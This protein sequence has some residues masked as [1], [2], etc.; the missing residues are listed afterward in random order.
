ML[1][2]KT[3]DKAP[4]N[5]PAKT[6]GIAPQFK[7]FGISD[8]K[9]LK[10]FLRSQDEYK[11]IDELPIKT[12]PTFSPDILNHGYS[13]SLFMVYAAICSRVDVGECFAANLQAIAQL[14]RMSVQTA[15]VHVPILIDEGWIEIVRKY[16]GFSPRAFRRLK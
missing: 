14:A 2:H 1:K 16:D 9:T 5:T 15:R 11:Y 7:H 12:A 8:P 3:A 10:S 13:G 4:D 6:P